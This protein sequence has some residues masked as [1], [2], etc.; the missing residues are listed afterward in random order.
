MVNRI[1]NRLR[2]LWLRV[3]SKHIQWSP[4]KKICITNLPDGTSIVDFYMDFYAK[5]WLE[6]ELTTIPTEIKHGK[7]GL[8]EE[9]TER[10]CRGK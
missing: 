10:I 7:S 8:H 3:R 6:P 4:D 2:Y 1:W 5:S 9:I